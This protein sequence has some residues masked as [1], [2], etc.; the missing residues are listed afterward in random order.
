[1]KLGSTFDENDRAFMW[2]A[3]HQDKNGLYADD[4]T[5]EVAEN[6]VSFLF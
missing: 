5:R 1:M 2:K 3:A 4:D 6:I